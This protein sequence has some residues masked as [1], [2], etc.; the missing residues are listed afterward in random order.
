MPRCAPSTAA[1]GSASSRSR[2]NQ[3]RPP[4]RAC[5]VRRQQLSKPSPMASPRANSAA[6]AEA[7]PAVER[8]EVALATQLASASGRLVPRSPAPPPNA[9]AKR[10]LTTVT[11]LG[12]PTTPPSFSFSFALRSESKRGN[13]ALT[14][15]PPL[16]RHSGE[17]PGARAQ[18]ALEFTASAGAEFADAAG[19]DFAER[20]GVLALVRTCPSSWCERSR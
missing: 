20:A 7:G 12:S 6:Q 14:R 15:T 4:S 13:L 8:V 1:W 19:A 17:T 18:H 11:K 3:G 10:I 16:G 2:A 5:R 9:H